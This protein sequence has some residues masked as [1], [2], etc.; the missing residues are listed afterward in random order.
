MN[1]L[2]K[3]GCVFLPL[4]ILSL[5]VLCSTESFIRV[6]AADIGYVDATNVRVRA[7]ASVN[8]KIYTKLSNVY[9]TINGE[10]KDNNGEIWYYITYNNITGYMHS[11]Y[12]KK[13]EVQPDKSF[14]EQLAAF[15]ESYRNQLIALHAEYPNWKFYADNIDL[16]LDEAVGLEI[17]RKLVQN[18]SKKS[19]LSMGL[20]AYDW[21]KE[22]WV[23]QDTNWYVAS[24]EVIKYYM[25][26]RNF[27]SSGYIYTF[28]KQNYDPTSQ[29]EEGLRKIISGTFLENGYSG[30]KDAYVKDIMA[31][32][33]SSGVNPYV[34][35]G[36]II[37]EQ[38]TNGTSPLISGTYPGYE[39]YY[40]FFNVKASGS[41]QAQKIESGL[42]YAAKEIRDK[43]GNI[44]K[45]KWN[46]RSKAIIGGAEFCGTKYVS[47]GQNT[48]YYMNFNI[49]N[50]DEIWHEYAG[51]VHNAS[52]SANIISKTYSSMKYADLEFL[53]P[54]YKNM[55]A[56]VSELPAKNDSLNNYY[57]KSIS[58]SGLT[59]TFSRFTYDYDLKI[60][61]DTVVKVTMP[62]G[63]S[64][65][66]A[67]YF[68]LKAG[69]NRVTLTVKAQTG[70]TNDYVIDV[71]ADKACVLYVDS[72]AGITPIDPDT[73]PT[74]DPTPEPQ[75]MRGDTN[76]D[77]KVDILDL[78]N[79]KRHILKVSTLSGNSFSAGDTNN[80]GV[81]DIIDLA[82]I[83]RH[84]LHII[85]LT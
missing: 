34:L 3:F 5:S 49:K 83:K 62:S 67:P 40:N 57:F 79:V 14:E 72:G 24:R 2:R 36:T 82:N 80:D 52:S 7:D 65:A 38:G 85:V 84:I 9:V 17:T 20:G 61:A 21:N 22:E 73:E 18:T 43:D 19:W 26:P 78:A 39:G 35:A 71:L 54:V 28:M 55:S 56:V 68:R 48:Y 1:I 16:T 29:T 46:S 74:P 32:A 69:Q 13:I 42:A 75:I 31:A 30:S 51:A 70:Y 15:P 12:I 37:Q 58:V 64:Y 25:E 50:P 10:K 27:L 8:S 53:I 66:G 63:A 81:I 4:I 76:G 33:K 60:S 47:V 77:G 45:E 41:T 44:I 11:D 6:N 23:P 59:P